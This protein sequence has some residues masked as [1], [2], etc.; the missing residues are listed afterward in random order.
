MKNRIGIVC[1]C[2]LPEKQELTSGIITLN[3]SHHVGPYCLLVRVR[4]HFLPMRARKENALWPLIPAFMH[5]ITKRAS[6]IY[7]TLSE[8]MTG[9]PFR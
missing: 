8:A 1:G 2:G 9:Q 5:E 6:G 3:Y 4:N 7:I